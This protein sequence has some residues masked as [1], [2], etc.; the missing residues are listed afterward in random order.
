MGNTPSV[1][2]C[3]LRT[4]AAAEIFSGAIHGAGRGV[5]GGDTTFG[6]V[7]VQTIIGLP[8]RGALRL[9]TARYYFADGRFLNPPDSAL[10][11]TGLAPDV[12]FQE[13]GETAF[14][15]MILSGFILYDFIESRWEMLRR[16][17]DEFDFPD[18]LVTLLR[19]YAESRGQIYRS[20][21][22]AVLDETVQQQ[23]L[24]QGAKEIITALDR[25]REVSTAFDRAVYDRER[26]F[27]TF[28]LRRLTIER[29]SGRSAAYRQVIVPNRPDIR[30]AAEVLLVP[31][32]YRRILQGALVQKHS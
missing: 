13:R 1:T 9:T 32:H 6:K 30:R 15:G 19:Q 5:V 16:L 26:D 8:R 29:K 12:V 7:L 27:L 25:L 4:A 10:T 2:G 20:R 24:D 23:R 14:R 28:H 18:T 21:M 22:T 11:F 17:P 3:A 31:D